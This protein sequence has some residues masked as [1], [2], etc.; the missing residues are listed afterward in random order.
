MA[1][2]PQMSHMKEGGLFQ[3]SVPEVPRSCVPL[4]ILNGPSLEPN[5]C[6][7]DRAAGRG[8]KIRESMKQLLGYE[9]DEL[10]EATSR[11]FTGGCP[12]GL[13]FRGAHWS[14]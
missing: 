7:G 2:A 11:F 6:G 13:I 12:V 4:C 10:L 14:S 3:S 1:V 5:G 8:A 9:I